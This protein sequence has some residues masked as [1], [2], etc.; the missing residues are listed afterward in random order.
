MMAPFD[1]IA[2]E[3]GGSVR[4]TDPAELVG[5]V[6]SLMKASTA[7]LGENDVAALMGVVD[8][9]GNTK[10]AFVIR[11]ENGWTATVWYE[12][13]DGQNNFGAGIMKTWKRR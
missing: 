7:T 4:E 13:E 5:S 11:T 2:E 9:H 12:R 8:Q 1:E 6:G 10:A 3:L